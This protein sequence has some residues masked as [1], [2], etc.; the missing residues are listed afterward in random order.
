[1]KKRIDRNA[2]A[3]T[4]S[5]YNTQ[6]IVKALDSHASNQGLKYLIDKNQQATQLLQSGQNRIFIDEAAG[7]LFREYCGFK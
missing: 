4:D 1:M 6:Q 7:I 3:N 2:S 5:Y